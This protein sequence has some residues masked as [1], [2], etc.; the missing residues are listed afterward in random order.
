[1]V[2][3]DEKTGKKNWYYNNYKRVQ[4]AINKT[5]ELRVGKII[6]YGYLLNLP[7]LVVSI[8]NTVNC[9]LIKFIELGGKHGKYN[10]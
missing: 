2:S 3:R 5:E 6:F 1:M 8:L 4:Q 10:N 9:I 7:S